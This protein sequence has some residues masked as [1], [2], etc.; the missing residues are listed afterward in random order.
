MSKTDEVIT[1]VK[2][3]KAKLVQEVHA[4]KTTAEL[5]R[6]Y[7][8]ELSAERGSGYADVVRMLEEVIAKLKT[9]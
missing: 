1:E 7:A 9:V 6:F 5:G 2:K 4:A 8:N 3:M